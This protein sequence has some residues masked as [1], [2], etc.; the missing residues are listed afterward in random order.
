MELHG[1]LSDCINNCQSWW[2]R[3]EVEES[4]LCSTARRNQQTSSQSKEKKTLDGSIYMHLY[5]NYRIDCNIVFMSASQSAS[6]LFIQMPFT[7]RRDVIGAVREE[8]DSKDYLDERPGN[9]KQRLWMW[10]GNNWENNCCT[11]AVGKAA[12]W[13]NLSQFVEK[14]KTCWINLVCLWKRFCFGESKCPRLIWWLTLHLLRLQIISDED[15][16]FEFAFSKTDPTL[17]L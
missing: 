7:A 6:M 11:Y 5:P 3:L 10:W 2:I 1:T 13:I 15:D 16:M 8:Y 4:Y 12:I 14:N 17:N 9:S